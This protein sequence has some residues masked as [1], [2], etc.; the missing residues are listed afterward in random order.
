MLPKARR[1]CDC[2]ASA[3]DSPP[4]PTGTI[5]CTWTN[6][7]GESSSW[8]SALSRSIQKALLRGDS[9]RS[10]LPT[11]KNVITDMRTPSFSNT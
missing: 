5:T 8:G 2:T 11:W 4:A 7:P 6:V 9:S 10:S 3:A 1:N